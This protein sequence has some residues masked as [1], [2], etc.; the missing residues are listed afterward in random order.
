MEDKPKDIEFAIEENLILVNEEVSDRKEII[1]KLGKLLYDYGF[2]KE[3]FTQAV[4]EREEAYPTGLNARVTG[5]A[6][7]HTDTIHVLKPAVAIAT[8]KNPVIFHGMGAPETEVEVR[9]VLM[10][11]VHNPKEVVNILRKIIFVIED[12]EAMRKILTANTKKEIK[13]V[14]KEHIQFLTKKMGV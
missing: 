1:N 6:V 8:L 11:A 3:S 4:L 2:V 10:L 9:V 12:D 5:V 14:L 13:D 7:P